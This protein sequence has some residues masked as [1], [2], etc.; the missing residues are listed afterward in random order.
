M[1]TPDDLLKA[2]S[3]AKKALTSFHAAA[4]QVTPELEAP[5][6]ARI[7]LLVWNVQLTWKEIRAWRHHVRAQGTK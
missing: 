2:A 3:N 5:L 7:E 1:L 4:K 6:R